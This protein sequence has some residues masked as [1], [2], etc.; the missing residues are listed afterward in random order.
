M[1]RRRTAIAAA[2]VGAALLD[3]WPALGGTDTGTLTVTAT[4]TNTCGLSGGTL[5]FGTYISGQQANLD[6]Q[7]SINY[8]NCQTG[9]LTLELD[10]G[11]NAANGQRRMKSGNNF[12]VYQIYKTAAR[13]TVW[14]SGSDA[15]QMQL[16]QSGSGS[17]PVYG[18]IPGGQAVPAGNYSDTVTI[19]L[20]F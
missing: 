19:T 6:V 16:L 7:G 11:A 15:L 9:V 1:A 12:L 13:T 14:G 17:I 2:L 4:V 8:T 20:T 5:A 10:N 3:G 18:R